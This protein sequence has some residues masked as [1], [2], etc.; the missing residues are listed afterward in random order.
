VHVARKLNARM[1]QDPQIVPLT[2]LEAH[3]V[4]HIDHNPGITSSRLAADLE[5]RTSNA[6]TVLRTL[7][8]KSL[9]RRE[10]SPDDRRVV[11]YTL[12]E[13]AVDSVERLHA[14]W[15]ADVGAAL[16]DA[17]DPTAALEVLRT[18]EDAL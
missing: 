14:Q 6:S 17:L 9:L 3:V 1:L 4:R 15:V 7:V 8:E 13:T 11:R 2:P 10:S 18:L 16:P 5:L 12:T